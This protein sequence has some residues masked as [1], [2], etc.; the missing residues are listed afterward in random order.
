M[1]SAGLP[2]AS[3]AHGADIQS[4]PPPHPSVSAFD[5]HPVIRLLFLHSLPLHLLP[6]LLS[7]LTPEFSQQESSRPPIS[8]LAYYYLVSSLQPCTHLWHESFLLMHVKQREANKNREGQERKESRA[9]SVGA[10][11]RKCN[12]VRF[13]KR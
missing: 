8:F 10:K 2:L 6:T 4:V 13:V 9:S 5:S 7:L 11:A 1:L 12:D 3:R